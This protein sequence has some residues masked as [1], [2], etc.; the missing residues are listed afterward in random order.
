MRTL[1]AVFAAAFD[2][3]VDQVVEADDLGLDEAALEV[4]VDDAGR[5]GSGR[6]DRDGPGPRLLRA[7]RQVGLQARACGSRPGSA[8]SGPARA[9]RSTSSSSRAS[10]SGRS[11]SSDSIFASMKTASAGA[12]SARSDVE[13]LLVAE[14]GLVDVEDVQ[15]RLRG[16][17]VQLVAARPGRSSRP[18]A[19]AYSVVPESSRSRAAVAA[20]RSRPRG[21]CGAVP[22]SPAAGSPSRASAGRRASARC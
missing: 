13:E 21:P 5:L 1:P 8:G 19:P 3:A 9:A 4:G 18:A 12:T 20:A 2:P 11:I 6:A 7:G 17:Q 22:P 16:Q 14:F 15:E 10:S